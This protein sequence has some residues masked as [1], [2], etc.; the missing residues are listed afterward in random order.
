M[1]TLKV[2][3]IT[4]EDATTKNCRMILV[5]GFIIAITLLILYTYSDHKYIC[6]DVYFNDEPSRNYIEYMNDESI[7]T[8]SNEPVSAKYINISNINRQ[9]I[10]IEKVNVIC[11]DRRII[12]IKR[13][14]AKIRRLGKK[15]ISMEFELHQE[16]EITHVVLDI[17]TW[18][19]S[20]K[21]MLTTQLELKDKNR[22]TIWSNTKPMT[23]DTKYINIYV[24]KPDINYETPNQVLCTGLQGNT[25]NSQHK[26][27]VKNLLNNTWEF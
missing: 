10:P 17:N 5:L 18:C 7:D 22:R 14:N 27:L 25:I 13:E 9:N 1:S 20:R 19:A 23:I 24:V 2:P 8:H 6:D 16:E 3:L 26:M 4:Q 12:P 21:N 15:G 11:L